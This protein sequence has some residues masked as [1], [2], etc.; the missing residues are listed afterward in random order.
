MLGNLTTNCLTPAQIA[1][2]E[3]IHNGPVDPTTGQHLYP[4]GYSLGSE[5]NWS[6]GTSANL[7]LTPG[8]T[9]T[10]ASFIT[11]WYQ[12]FTFGTPSTGA[13]PLDPD[14]SQ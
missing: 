14:A 10:P 2:V 4:G 9:V 12:D 6:N 7:P 5:F 1:V 11:A 3:K 13:P 8:G